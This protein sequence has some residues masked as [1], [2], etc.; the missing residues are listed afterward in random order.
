[1]KLPLPWLKKYTDVS[2]STEKLANRLTMSGNKVESVEGRPGEEV[3]DIEV[4]TNRPDCLSILGL[5]QE[6]S[7]I[8]GKKIRRPLAYFSKKN[9]AKTEKSSP[10]ISIED[11]KGCPR[12]T[13]RVIRNVRVTSS[14][15]EIE[16]LLGLVGTRAISNVV[17]ATNYVLFECGQPMHAFDLDKI[18]GDQIIVRRAKKSEK[19]LGID[20]LEYH[21][22]EKTLIIADAK[23]PIAIAGVIGGKLTEVTAATK[24]VLL[25]SA[26][27]DPALVRQAAKKYKIS[28]ESGY[29]FERGV[30][31]ENVPHASLRA[32]ELIEQW[33]GGSDVS[34]LIDKN[35]SHPW[36]PKPVLLHLASAEKILGFKI[37]QRR[38]SGIFKSLS[39]KVQKTG[40]G[41]IKVTPDSSRKDITLEA[42]LME[43]LL[44]I[45]GFDKGPETLP[46]SRYSRE[47]FHD[48]KAER[49]PE[50]KNRVACLG[51]DEIMTYSLL[52]ES[53]LVQSGIDPRRCHAVMNAVSAEQAYFRPSL[54]PGMLQSILY[55]VHRKAS[56]LKFFEI[57]NCY[58]DQREE[59][60]LALALY[61]MSEENWQ[62]KSESTF[63]D[64]KGVLENVLNSF[65]L[66]SWD[67]REEVLYWNEKP[68]AHLQNVPGEILGNSGIPHEVFFCEMILDEVLLFDPPSWKV[69]PVP[70]YPKA[71][72]DIAFM[73]DKR[74]SVKDIERALR[75]AGAPYLREAVLFD[76][77]L[78]KNIPSGKRSLA[79]S[80]AYQKETGTFTE[81][82][83]QTLQTKLGEALKSKFQ[84]EFR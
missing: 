14:P 21:L 38:A 11:K 6:V 25:E 41:K 74:I 45:E 63:F 68:L 19:F 36:K 30:N 44:R 80:L 58:A 4:T 60:R 15:V 52:S 51:F 5:A 48:K 26:Y 77:Y 7:A 50:L 54:L 24:N 53:R 69:K 12:Y 18:E 59:T 13:A 55:N 47:R 82:E 28:T 34:G 76:Q 2:I 37:S 35:Y 31:Q 73:V 67:W 20:G 65:R 81:E 84:V 40:A 3:I 8:T 64:L 46:V 71:R 57:G 70:K 72:R 9:L 23:Q 75:E 83:I 49:I 56:G 33:A 43:E 66:T 1:M 61:G 17:D 32:Y 62:R 16:R 42:D 79:F 39:F 10:A 22:D 27:F 78:G 29:R